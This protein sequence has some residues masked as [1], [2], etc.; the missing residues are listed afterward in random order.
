[1]TTFR[2]PI[3]DFQLANPIYIGASVTFY[4][5]DGAGAATTTKATLYA[6]P[7]GT[8]TLA[9]PQT[10]DSYGKFSAPVYIAVDVIAEAV[11]ANV[12][13]HQTGIISTSG[14]I[15]TPASLT[16]GGIPYASSITTLGCSA[17]LAQYKLVY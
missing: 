13:S 15:D 16:S 7:A 1:M 14:S 12:P 4:T 6:D 11:G 9:N 17:L 2:T 10:L 8:D 5:V 3:T